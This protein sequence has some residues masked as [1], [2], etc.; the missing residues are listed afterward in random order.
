MYVFENES[1]PT[2]AVQ[3]RQHEDAAGRWRCF[4][5]LISMFTYD[6]LQ[7]PSGHITPNFPPPAERTI[8]R[9]GTKTVRPPQTWTAICHVSQ[10]RVVWQAVLSVSK[11]QITGTSLSHARIE[12]Q[13]AQRLAL[14]SL[15]MPTQICRPCRSTQPW[16][17]HTKLRP[18]APSNRI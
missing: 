5:G 3:K 10:K 12:K 11:E 1:F 17:T 2:T 14:L 7:I 15:I 4:S 9:K 16:T 18:S 8:Y 13:H 6:I